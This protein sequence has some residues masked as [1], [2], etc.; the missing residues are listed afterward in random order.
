[1]RVGSRDNNRI[2]GSSTC[3]TNRSRI[4]NR[5]YNCFFQTCI[6]NHCRKHGVIVQDGLGRKHSACDAIT[7]RLKLNINFY[8]N[9]IPQQ[10][11]PIIRRLLCFCHSCCIRGHNRSEIKL[12]VCATSGRCAWLHR[13]IIVRINQRI[14]IRLNARTNCIISQRSDNNWR[15][16][17]AQ[18]LHM[19]TNAVISFQRSANCLEPGISTS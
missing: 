5:S 14:T 2:V 12:D 6:C 16:W 8:I 15:F 13:T 9:F 19:T 11:S 18:N 10:R 1:M 3:D 17:L 7:S 4:G